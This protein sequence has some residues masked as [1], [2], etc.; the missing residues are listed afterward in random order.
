MVGVWGAVY[1]ELLTLDVPETHLPVI[2]RLV[3]F[4][5]GGSSLYWRVSVP[6]TLT[7]LAGSLGPTRS[8]RQASSAAGP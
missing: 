7:V 3:E 2:D 8:T 5:P 1:G 6:M 4:R